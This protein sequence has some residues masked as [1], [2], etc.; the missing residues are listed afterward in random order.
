MRPYGLANMNLQWLL[1]LAFGFLLVWLT[2]PS[3][4]IGRTDAVFEK[5][6]RGPGPGDPC[7]WLVARCGGVFEIHPTAEV[8]VAMRVGFRSRLF[9]AKKS[10]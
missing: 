9:Q 6:R 1:M 3:R 10:E 2:G 5:T 8:A 4:S 7:V